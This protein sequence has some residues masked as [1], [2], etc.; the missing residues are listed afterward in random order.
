MSSRDVKVKVWDGVSTYRYAHLKRDGIWLSLVKATDTIA[1]WTR[2]PT[3][4]TALAEWH[5]TV[6]SFRENAPPMTTLFCECFVEGG[7]RD[8]VKGALRDQDPRLRIECF[9]VDAWHRVKPSEWDER[10]QTLTVCQRR[11]E[12]INVPFVPFWLQGLVDVSRIP[13][14]GEGWVLKDANLVN[15]MKVKSE[16]TYDLRVLGFSEATKGS[17][18][19]GMV[20]SVIL[21]DST[22]NE[23]TRASGMPDEIRKHMTEWPQWWIGRVVEVEAQGRGSAGG[24]CHPRYVRWRDDKDTVDTLT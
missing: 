23:V 1:V 13:D 20:G 24:L 15:W 7:S 19:D 8:D 10:W 11:C 9:A 2:H 22:G 16:V 21:A 4:Y 5:P 17:K 18:Y 3:N 14:G 12:S 6:V